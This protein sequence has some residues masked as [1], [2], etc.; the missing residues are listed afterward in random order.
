MEAIKY[1]MKLLY[2]R[3]TITAETP[4]INSADMINKGS[5]VKPSPI[6]ITV[7]HVD[8][9][10]LP[11]AYPNTIT[12]LMKKI[13]E[14]RLAPPP[15]PPGLQPTVLPQLIES[16]RKD[17][18]T[19]ES[20]LTDLS[21]DSDTNN[22]ASPESLY[23]ELPT[24]VLEQTLL[25]S[26]IERVP[27]AARLKRAAIAKKHAEEA[28]EVERKRK[29][30]WLAIPKRLRGR[31]VSRCLR[32]S[33]NL[34]TMF[35]VYK[36]PS[37]E[38]FFIFSGILMN[39]STTEAMRCNF[40]ILVQTISSDQN[41]LINPKDW[42]KETWRYLAWKS[43]KRIVLSDRDLKNGKTGVGYMNSGSVEFNFKPLR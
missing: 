13:T 32:V 14:N 35:S 39:A 33:S 28:E 4:I 41:Y 17:P 23:E 38:R 7:D 16:D 1:L 8:D 19:E 31:L 5:S 36:L 18:P 22:E 25:I 37:K 24:P 21:A 3:Y 42:T 34:F 26:P 15:A 40:N 11:D 12:D 30:A 29:E 20:P 27:G 6:I 2:I 43:I 10:S 9:Y